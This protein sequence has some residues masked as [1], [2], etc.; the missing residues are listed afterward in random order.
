MVDSGDLQSEGGS[1]VRLIIAGSRDFEVTI[2]QI[3]EVIRTLGLQVSEVVSGMARGPDT[4]G[5]LWA[6]VWGIPVKQFPADW[7][8][9][10]R[11]AGP[12]RNYEMGDYGTHLLAFWDG[13][14][15][16][17]AHMIA[18][19]KKLGKPY[20]VVERGASCQMEIDCRDPG[21]TTTPPTGIESSEPAEDD[22]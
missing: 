6:K 7:E 4:K 17:T 15:P 19:M 16:G 3:G 8:K 10:G 21:T 14:S 13:E 9:H 12:L 22:E 1:G 11:R 2:D 20:Y 5:L 18:Y